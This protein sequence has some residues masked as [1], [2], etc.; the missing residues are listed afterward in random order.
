[1]SRRASALKR[2]DWGGKVPPSARHFPAL[3]DK[4]VVETLEEIMLSQRR[5]RRVAVI[6][7]LVGLVVPGLHKFYLGQYRWGA[8][9]LVVGLTPIAAIARA[10]SLTDALLYLMRSSTFDPAAP[11]ERTENHVP[12]KSG[13]LTGRFAF[14]PPAEPFNP[15]QVGAIADAIRHLEQLRQEGLI[16]EYEVEQKRRQLLEQMP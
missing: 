5:D 3:N 2:D 9:Y 11:P 6:L 16:S 14:Q 4:P 12:P 13:G 15:Q 7:A 1:M 10:A 8:L